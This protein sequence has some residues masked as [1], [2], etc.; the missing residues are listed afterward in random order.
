M[1]D[2]RA[3]VVDPN[4]STIFVVDLTATLISI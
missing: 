3:V 2:I 4:A 1:A